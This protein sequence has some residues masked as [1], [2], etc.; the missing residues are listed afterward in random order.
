MKNIT[1]ILLLLMVVSCSS[2]RVEKTNHDVDVSKN[3]TD[4]ALSKSDVVCKEVAVVGTRFKEKRC[5]SA[6][7]SDAAAQEA[8][9]RMEQLQGAG[10]AK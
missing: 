7:S 1:L 10:S 3:A 9:E 2:A 5:R 6:R 4:S 8:R